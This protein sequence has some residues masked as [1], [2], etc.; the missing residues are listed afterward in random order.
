[1]TI[2]QCIVSI[3]RPLRNPFVNQEKVHN[4]LY[5]PAVRTY[6]SFLVFWW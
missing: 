3:T 5:F 4:F 2:V 1:M 6:V